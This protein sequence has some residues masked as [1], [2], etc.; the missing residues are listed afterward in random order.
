MNEPT[1]KSPGPTRGNVEM[2]RC[3]DVEMWRCGDVEMGEGELVGAG[4]DQAPREAPYPI[5]HPVNGGEVKVK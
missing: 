1:S 3:G 5:A 4:G 2:W